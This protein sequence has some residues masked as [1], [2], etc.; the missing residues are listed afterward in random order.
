M[1]DFKT[2]IGGNF[3]YK[4]NR[5]QQLR[6][7]CFAAQYGNISHAAKSMGL[8]HTSVSLQ[9]KALEEDIGCVLF[10]R[11]GPKIRLTE[12][13]AKLLEMAQPLVDSIHNLYE[14]FHHEVSVKI[15]SELHI[16]ANASGK[17]FLL[18]RILRDYLELYPSIKAVVHY[19][20]HHEAMKLLEKGAADIAIL[21]RHDHQPFPKACEYIPIFYCKPCLITLPDHPLAGRKNLLVS[22]I[23]RYPLALPTKELQVIPN[24]RETFDAIGKKPTRI[25][26]TNSDTFREYIEAGLVSTVAPD[27]WMREDDWLVATSL[28]HLFPDTD[29]GM[30]RLRNKT[31]PKHVRDLLDLMRQHALKRHYPQ[32][33]L[34]Q[35]AARTPDAITDL[36]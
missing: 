16:A 11:Q 26:F 3:Y 32:R 13:G 12:E 35:A 10:K 1:S 15:N 5:L 25:E 17:N 21:A 19:V 4:H 24:L 20:E 36:A 14:Q 8:A 30:V 27:I 34:R 33:S 2:K 7:F 22:E 31:M 29:Y 18:P 9:I 6:G 28:S 23:S